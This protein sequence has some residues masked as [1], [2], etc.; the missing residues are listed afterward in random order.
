MVVDH[1]RLVG[2]ISLNDLMAFVAAE[3]ALEGDLLPG[4]RAR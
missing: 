1:E 4:A 2:V 3:L